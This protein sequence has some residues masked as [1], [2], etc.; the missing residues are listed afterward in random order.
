[1]RR[2]AAGVTTP[3]DGAIP[4]TGGIPCCA[5][6]AQAGVSATATAVSTA[7]GGLIEALPRA[8]S[9]LPFLRRRRGTLHRSTM[10]VVSPYAKRNDVLHTHDQF[11]SIY[12]A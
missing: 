11:G 3:R 2:L 4:A 8:I 9:N 5:R 7:I 1:M 12:G 10:L 6:G